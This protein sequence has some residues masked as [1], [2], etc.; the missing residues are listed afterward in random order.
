MKGRFL[1]SSNED[2][3][4]GNVY[5]DKSSLILDWLL[6][7]GVSKKSFSLREVAKKAEVSLG[8]AQRVFSILVLKGFLQAEGIRTAK[9]F[10]FN[11]PKELLESWLEHYS[12]LKKC[13][14]MTYTS[15]LSG[16]SEWFKAL[17][18]FGVDQNVILALHSAAES[19]GYK[20]TNLEGLELYIL[21]PLMRKKLE[22]AL[23]LDPQERGY[24]VLL[25][26]PYYKM[27]LNQN[28]K[29][30]KEIGVCP[31]LLTFLDLYHFPLR[32]QEQAEFIAQRAPELKHIY[33]RRKNK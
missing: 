29:N 33:K 30:G 12:I 20:N 25:I 14:I 28:R 6:R 8:L 21:D 22:I 1:I 9:K 16:K 7:E 32:G 2:P 27:L 17:K 19:Y 13:K 4:E 23:Q 11:K 24:E 18:K 3:A 10:L 26:E 5:A 31:L 15:A